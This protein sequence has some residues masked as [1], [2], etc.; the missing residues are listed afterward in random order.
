MHFDAD[1]SGLLDY[2]EFRKCLESV[3]QSLEEEE[4]AKVVAEVDTS[5][6]GHIGFQVL[7]YTAFKSIVRE[8][9][10]TTVGTRLHET[11]HP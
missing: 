3:G 6:D 2:E 8:A 7:V 9:V 10:A 4:L 5:G 1:E 11:S